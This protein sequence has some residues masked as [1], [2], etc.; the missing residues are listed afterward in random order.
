MASSVAY[1]V[2]DFGG[3]WEDSWEYPV[4]AFTDEGRARECAAKRKERRLAQRLDDDWD[5]YTGST[6]RSVP[7]VMD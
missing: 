5:D 6:V 3:E 4:I 7:L 1:V 2:S